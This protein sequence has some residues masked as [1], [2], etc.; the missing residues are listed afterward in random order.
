MPHCPR[1][2]RLEMTSFGS[3]YVFLVSASGLPTTVGPTEKE[4]TS[5]QKPGVTCEEVEPLHVS[6][7]GTR[8][9]T[10]QR[11]KFE[12]DAW[13]HFSEVNTGDIFSCTFRLA[14]PSSAGAPFSIKFGDPPAS[15]VKRCTSARPI[16]R[17]WRRRRKTMTLGRCF[18]WLEIS[19]GEH[20][21][22]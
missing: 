7:K 2:T 11:W 6:H 8:F 4:S 10:P 16:S 3:F 5:H 12:P 17:V 21:P 15:L 14:N 9:Y 19:W 13:S 22:N 18:E 1:N 20:G